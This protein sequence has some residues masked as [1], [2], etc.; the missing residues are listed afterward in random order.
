MSCFIYLCVPAQHMKQRCSVNICRIKAKGKSNSYSYS[1]TWNKL[2]SWDG[3]AFVQLY[4]WTLGKTEGRRW[5]G[6]QKMRWLDGITDS[7]DMSLSK[8]R[9][10]VMDREAWRAA[11]LGLQGVRH[12]WVTELTDI[13]TLKWIANYSWEE[14]VERREGRRRLTC[15]YRGQKWVKKM[16][17]KRMVLDFTVLIENSTIYTHLKNE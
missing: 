15:G 14:E 16:S 2:N 3:I 13:W 6:R 8:L 7:M 9:E 11:V 17:D 4:I 12:D 1:K 5:R 10:L